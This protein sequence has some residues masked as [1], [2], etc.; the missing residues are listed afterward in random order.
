MIPA[1]FVVFAPA[2][3]CATL[4]AHADITLPAIISDNMVLQQHARIN[5]WGKADSKESVTVQLGPD[6]AQTTAGPDG[7]WGV[8]LDGLKG[9]GPY[10]LT[11]YGKNSISIHNVAVGEVWVCSGESNMEFKTVAATNGEEEMAQGDLPMVRVFTVWHNAAKAPRSDCEGAWVVCD[12]DTVK[13]VSAVGYFFARELN[14]SMRVPIGLIQSA[15]GP[16]PIEAWTP[17]GTLEKDP[18]L[19]AAL[20]RYDK[21]AAA[22]PAALAAYQ[23]KLA[24]WNAAKAASSPAARE[25]LA[26]L[27]PGGRRE[28]GALYDGMI[29]PLTRYPIRGALWYQGESNTYEPQLYRAL[30]PTM[31]GAWRKAWD[32]GDFPFLYVQLSTFFGRHPQPQESRWAELREA[33]A[34]ALS[35]PKTGMA[36][37]V[38]IGEEHNMHPPDKQDVAHRLALLAESAAYGKPGIVASGPVF[39][40]MEIADGNATLS[41]KQTDGGLEVKNGPP[42]K[43]FEIAGAD[44]SFVWADAAIHGDQVIVRSNAVPNPVAVRYAWADTPDCGLFNKANLPAAPFRTDD[45]SPG[46]AS[47]SPTPGASPAPTPRK[48]TRHHSE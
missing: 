5:V 28:P 46:I 39:S 41:F 14:R 31:I 27:P 36:V 10:D 17:R 19:H 37:T 4:L 11:V 47:A 20:D 1:S 22:F 33:Q 40:G 15:W 8:K 43:G 25:P 12:P 21:A 48:H 42:L 30:F 32:E 13:N 9:G 45:W 26:P 23:A 6:T 7:N 2:L 44:R 24:D 34:D 18:T 3:L 38:D 35:L 29:A 16:S